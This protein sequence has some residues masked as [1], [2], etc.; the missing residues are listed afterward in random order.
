MSE[1]SAHDFHNKG[2][3]DY[4]KGVYN[5]PSASLGDQLIA[6]V[7]PVTAQEV[8]DTAEDRKAY[9]EGRENAQKQK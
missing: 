9:F 4:S 6:I 1:K 8:K 5:P 2:Q 3:E 7:N